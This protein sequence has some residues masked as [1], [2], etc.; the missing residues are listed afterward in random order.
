MVDWKQYQWTLIYACM[1]NLNVIQL[2]GGHC[3]G[4]F[5]E[6]NTAWWH[7]S[8]EFLYRNVKSGL[9]E[10]DT[11]PESLSIKDIYHLCK[12]YLSNGADQNDLSLYIYFIGTDKLINLISKHSMMDWSKIN[13]DI[14]MSFI[15][16]LQD[17]YK[18]AGVA[19]IQLDI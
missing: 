15:K 3:G 10:I 14:N 13:D 7:A 5:A 1:E 6:D 4:Q 12:H 11:C 16:E 18:S 2:M 9:L 19:N 17:V 8:I